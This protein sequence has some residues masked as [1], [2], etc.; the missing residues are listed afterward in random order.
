MGNRMIKETIRTSRSIGLMTDFQF[1]TWVYLITYVDDYGRGSAD[2]EILKGLVFTRRKGITE[3][4]IE[5]TL[6][7]LA[8]IGSIRLY[9]VGGERYFCFPNWSDHQRVQQKRS[10]YPEPPQEYE[11]QRK[12]TVSHGESPPEVETET[13][14]ETEFEGEYEY[15]AERGVAASAPPVLTLPLNDKTEYPVTDSD[16]CEWQSLY[17][18]VDVMQELRNMRGWLLSNPAKR[19][20]RSGIKRFVNAWLAREQNKGGSAAMPQQK[21]GRRIDAMDELNALYRQFRQ[22]E[23]AK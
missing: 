16:L 9:E 6:L 8:N 12:S 18:A 2:P 19:K 10:K 11:E 15:C 23:G 1:R 4:T 20:T 21:T 14:V 22:E 3:A 7:D 5:K 13:E 17:P